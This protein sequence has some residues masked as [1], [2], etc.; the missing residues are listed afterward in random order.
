MNVSGDATLL[1]VY[2]NT[3]HEQKTTQDL[4]R[5]NAII[6]KKKERKRLEKENIQSHLL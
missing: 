2:I 1:V 5:V 3:K 6:V 4:S